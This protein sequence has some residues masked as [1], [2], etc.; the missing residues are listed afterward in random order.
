MKDLAERAEMDAKEAEPTEEIPKSPSVQSA[1]LFLMQTL[2]ETHKANLDF[3]QALVF[4]PGDEPFEKAYAFMTDEQH[5]A[6]HPNNAQLKK[7]EVAY[8][9]NVPVK[10]SANSE[11]V[12][13]DASNLVV[14]HAN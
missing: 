12:A 6:E 5:K 4:K 11:L 14:G 7:E 2:D 10:G 8:F 1:E 3:S 9:V 13:I